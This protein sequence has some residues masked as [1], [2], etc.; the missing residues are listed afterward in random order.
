MVFKHLRTLDFHVADADVSFVDMEHLSSDEFL[1]KRERGKNILK[2]ID[3]TSIQNLLY[4]LGAGR[5]KHL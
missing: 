1:K 3:I 2:V 5:T 4:A